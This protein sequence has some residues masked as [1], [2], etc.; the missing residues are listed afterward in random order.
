MAR[1]LKVFSGSVNVLID[2]EYRQCRVIMATTSKAN[3]CK[4]TG[5]RPGYVQGGGN[6]TQIALD[7]PETA[8]VNQNGMNYPNVYI[9]GNIIGH[10]RIS[11]S[12]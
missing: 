1:K 3:F 5:M 10:G 7:A 11:V 2:G 9:H 4:V 8:L 12:V 6:D